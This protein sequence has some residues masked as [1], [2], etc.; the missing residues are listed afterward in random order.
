MMW[1]VFAATCLLFLASSSQ[2]V[3]I[4]LADFGPS[5]VTE[6]FEGITAADPNVG[7]TSFATVLEPAIT[8]PYFFPSGAALFNAPNPGIFNDGPFIHDFSLG[9][10]PSND[11][12]ANGTVSSAADVPSGS[13]YLGAFDSPSPPT[14]DV[15][16]DFRF[17]QDMQRVG[18]VATGGEGMMA[19]LRVYDAS[20]LLLESLTVS[21][22]PVGQ[23]DTNF[24]GIE[25]SEGIRRAVFSGPDL[26]LDDLIFEALVPEP[27]SFSLTAFGLL[28]LAVTRRSLRG[29][30]R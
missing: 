13:A 30:K 5:A 26:G 12:G 27:S 14:N 10:G 24:L 6:D 23:W 28:G 21:T 29:R 7:S 19:T 20:D 2:A 17:S 16:I 25:R 9:S 15:L 4:S 22:V 8:A 3:Q 1:R 11:W 18:A